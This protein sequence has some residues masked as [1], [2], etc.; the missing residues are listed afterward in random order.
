MKDWDSNFTPSYTPLEMLELG[1]FE[2]KY[3]NGIPGVPKE[4]YDLPKVLKVYQKPDPSLNKF[5]VKSRMSLSE[6]RDKGWIDECDPYGW[7]EWYIKYFLGRRIREIDAKQIWR[8]H[9]FISRHQA[10]VTKGCNLSDEACRPKQRQGL[11]QWAWD[12]ST[13]YA[14][15]QR[16]LNRKRIIKL[17]HDLKPLEYFQRGA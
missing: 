3:I 7:F 12:S 4:W 2:G 9:S 15:H 1:V 14:I 16:N 6:W 5:G 17:A 11:L 8:W 13:P 10:Q